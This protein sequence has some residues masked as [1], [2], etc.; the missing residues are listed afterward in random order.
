MAFFRALS[1][2]A[3]CSFFLFSLS[4]ENSS[5]KLTPA[6]EPAET[7]LDP[8]SAPELGKPAAN[9]GVAKAALEIPYFY[10]YENRNEPGGTC[11]VTSMAMVLGALMP[12]NKKTPDELY[13]KFG[14]AAGQ[15]PERISETFRSLGLSAKGTRTGTRAQMKAHLDAG[16]LIVTHGYFTTEGHVVAVVGHNAKGWIVN[17]PAGIYL[18]CYNC[19]ARGKGVVYA[20]GS[21]GDTVLST[22][23]DVWFTAVSK[24]P[25]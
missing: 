11:G 19:K 15:S 9:G 22:D 8:R 21:K 13:V 10:Q 7:P 24:T 18:E 6:P 25:F 12:E 17:D 5:G 16:R 2:V 23:G 3:F 4:C 14:K 1:R 20:F